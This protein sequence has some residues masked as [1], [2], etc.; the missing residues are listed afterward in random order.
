MG[1][2]ECARCPSSLGPKVWHSAQGFR[3]L[4]KS[5]ILRTKSQAIP[6]GSLI[7][8]DSL[9]MGIPDQPVEPKTEEVLRTGS[10]ALYSRLTVELRITGRF[11][12]AL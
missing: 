3:A 4:D 2:A 8:L 5:L 11:C 9:G 6:R 10:A 7:G 1:A 12:S